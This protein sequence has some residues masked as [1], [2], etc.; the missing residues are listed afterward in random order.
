L[1]K[2]AKKRRKTGAAAAA[3]PE[4]PAA[5]APATASAAA[6]P[7]AQDEKVRLPQRFPHLNLDERPYAAPANKFLRDT[8][9]LEWPERRLKQLEKQQACGE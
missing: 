4:A 5:A 8:V 9:T 7:A 3:A 6:A 1:E 2:R